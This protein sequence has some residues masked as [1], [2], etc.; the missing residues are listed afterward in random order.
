[1]AE[2][3]LAQRGDSGIAGSGR[4]LRFRC[5]N[6]K[7]LS[8]SS[9]APTLT[10]NAASGDVLT[11]TPAGSPSSSVCKQAQHSDPQSLL[12]LSATP[13]ATPQ[14]SRG[15]CCLL[16]HFLTNLCAPL[17][18]KGPCAPFQPILP[19][20]DQLLHTGLWSDAAQQPFLQRAPC[21]M[22]SQKTT[23]ATLPAGLPRPFLFV[24]FLALSPTTDH[25]HHET[26]LS[27]LLQPLVSL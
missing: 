2:H 4:V 19:T 27:F 22:P 16:L 26:I 18:A 5:P 9:P 8:N 24:T 17:L 15:S 1:M 10:A 20:S 21:Q 25:R 11:H 14:R 13:S 12:L 23:T 7:K 3:E 6:K